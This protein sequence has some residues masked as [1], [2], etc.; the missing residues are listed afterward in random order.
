ML[1]GFIK[2]KCP[3]CGS[4]FIAPDMEDNATVHSAP[5]HCPECG[6]DLRPD[7][8]LFNV[9]ARLLKSLPRKNVCR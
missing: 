2:V 8:A 3:H 7:R 9:L 4:V 1:R 5:I 6:M